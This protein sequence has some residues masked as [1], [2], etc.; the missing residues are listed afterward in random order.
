MH[1]QIQTFLSWADRGRSILMAVAVAAS[2]TTS[3]ECLASNEAA[4]P[5]TAKPAGAR[6]SIGVHGYWIIDVRNPDGTLDQ[7]LEFENQLC[8]TFTDTMSNLSI[9]GGDSI[10]TSLLGGEF[11]LNPSAPGLWSIVLGAT[12]ASTITPNSAAPGGFIAT[13][14]PNCDFTTAAYMIQQFGPTAP[15]GLSGATS[16]PLAFAACSPSNCAASLTATTTGGTLTLQASFTA[17][18][19]LS[20]PIQITAVG[21]D[22][23]TCNS[24][25]ANA[26]SCATISFNLGKTIGAN[27]A[28]CTFTGEYVSPPFATESFTNCDSASNDTIQVLSSTV[29]GQTGH[30]PFSGVILTPGGSPASFTI[31]ASQLVSVTWNL[32]FH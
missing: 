30:N 17:P 5:T 28:A 24:G 20:A 25:F 11:A 18:A 10:L 1:L 32:S 31:S 15:T 19:T 7:H 16:P 23:Y 2:L 3:A 13:P 8:T 4:A 6:D 14:A 21:T 29:Q 22:L 9:R 12:G 27:T 26:N